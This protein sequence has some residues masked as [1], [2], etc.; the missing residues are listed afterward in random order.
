[1]ECY[2]ITGLSVDIYSSCI[3]YIFYT[4]YAIRKKYITRNIVHRLDVHLFSLVHLCSIYDIMYLKVS[5]YINTQEY[6]IKSSFRKKYQ[7]HIAKA[8]AM[9]ASIHLEVWIDGGKLIH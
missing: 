1:M 4:P 8:N 6:Y 9:F 5:T 3:L 7:Y 2:P